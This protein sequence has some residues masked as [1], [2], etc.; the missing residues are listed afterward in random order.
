MPAAK[1]PP[2][3]DPFN[4]APHVSVPVLML[5][6]DSDFIYEVNP[7]QKPLF[8]RL[9]TLP[10]Q[11]RHGIYPGGHGSISELRSRFVKD[12]LDWLDRYLGPAK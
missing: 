8:T 4:F 10:D 5:N 11:K 6:G 2:E 7:A 3:V 12:I 1:A 9:G